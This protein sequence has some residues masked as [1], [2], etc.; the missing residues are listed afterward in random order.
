[1]WDQLRVDHGEFFLT[2]YVQEKLSQHRHNTNRLPYIQTISSK[3]GRIWPEVSNRV[4]YPLK[5]ALVHLLDKELIDMEDNI[6]TFCISNL[7]CQVSQI[8]QGRV[9][10]SWNA[11]RIPGRGI[12]YDLAAGGCA[13][14]IPPRD[15]AQCW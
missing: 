14:R 10:L 5:Q 7:S 2:L 6:N 15:A 13:A 9:V 4:N 1:M 8:G 3:T 12:P 11:H